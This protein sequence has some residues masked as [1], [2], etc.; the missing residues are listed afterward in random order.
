MKK[1]HLSGHFTALAV[2]RLTATETDGAVSRQHEFDGVQELKRML[3]SDRRKFEATFT[4]LADDDPEPLRGDGTLTWYDARENDPKRSEWR[5]YYTDTTVSNNFSVGDLLILAR[6]PDD[7]LIVVIAE[8]GSTME[9]QLLWLFGVG[10]VVNPEFSVKGEIE[11]GHAKLE[12]AANHI[13]ELIGEPIEIADETYLDRMLEKFG[14]AFPKTREFSRFARSTLSGVDEISDPD[15]AMLAWMERE[16]I[17]FRTME[18]HLIGDS[19]QHGTADVD[20]LLKYFM[21]I[22]QRRRSRVG[23]ALENHLEHLFGRHGVTF[24]RGKTTEGRA[25]PD[26]VFPNIE[27]YHALEVDPVRLTM[28]GVKATCRDRWR[29]VLAEAGRIPI[30]HLY[31]LEASISEGQTTEMGS[32]GVQLVLPHALHQ[33]FKPSQRSLLLATSEF[34]ELVTQRAAALAQ[35]SGMQTSLPD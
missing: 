34:I 15:G 20:V 27:A 24:S 32:H 33:T 9:S 26:F 3:G 18:K 21:T 6:R 2:K 10:D 4:Y 22:F 19:L 16:E 5:L 31:T 25:K 11:S 12:F 30:K 7:R 1:G 23:Y 28:L 8:Q 14:G 29:Q 13:L 17:L 35:T